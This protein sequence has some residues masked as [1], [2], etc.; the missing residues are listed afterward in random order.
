M[1]F[2]NRSADMYVCNMYMSVCIHTHLQTSVCIDTFMTSQTERK[3][4]K[5][6]ERKTKEKKEKDKKK[7]ERKSLRI[8]HRIY[9][10]TLIHILHT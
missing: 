3:K 6:K 4:E 7:K 9:T 5:K 1:Y 10:H 2:D 8:R